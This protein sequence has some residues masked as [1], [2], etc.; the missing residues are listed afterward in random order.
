MPAPADV[1]SLL[2]LVRPL[3]EGADVEADTP[4][5][6]TGILDSFAIGELLDAVRAE[7]G[8]DL[9]VEEVGVDNADT[10][11]QLLELLRARG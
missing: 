7:Y 4:L 6:S 11:E 2:E 10:P 5:L 3:A 8:V 1:A 9:P